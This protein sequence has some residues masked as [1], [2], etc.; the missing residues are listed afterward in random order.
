M[1]REKLKIN[2]DPVERERLEVMAEVTGRN[3]ASLIRSILRRATPSG[4]ADITL[5]A[6]TVREGS[7]GS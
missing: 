2:L 3:L 4:H 5:V 1:R 6:S 7:R